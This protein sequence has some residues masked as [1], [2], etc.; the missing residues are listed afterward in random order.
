MSADIGILAIGIFAAVVIVMLA[1]GNKKTSGRNVCTRCSGTG[2]INEKWPDPN[3]PG[4]WHKQD[5]VC[6]KC[7]GKGRV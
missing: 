4:G 3:K 1:M 6:P 2:E 5:G 7:K